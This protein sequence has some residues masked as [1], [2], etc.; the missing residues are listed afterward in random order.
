MSYG[1]THAFALGLFGWTMIGANDC[2]LWTSTSP[3]GPG[4]APPPPPPQFCLTDPPLDCYAVCVTD[5]VIVAMM[6]P[7][8]PPTTT[9]CGDSGE[10][11]KLFKTDAQTILVCDENMDSYAVFPP[12]FQI[13][14]MVIETG[15]GCVQPPAL[16]AE[17]PMSLLLNLL[18]T[19]M[20]P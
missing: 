18:Q 12:K 10:L 3:T 8:M 2:G 19:G 4:G 6:G 20:A 1:K 16:P 17:M 13:V 7:D 5:P 11:A 15:D 9:G 14:P